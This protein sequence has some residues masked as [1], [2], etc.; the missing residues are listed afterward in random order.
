M[1]GG[2]QFV[3]VMGWGRLR[4]TGSKAG[5]ASMRTGIFGDFGGR[6]WTWSLVGGW[7]CVTTGSGGC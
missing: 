7:G 6:L 3:P 2:N 5:T 1:A 4:R